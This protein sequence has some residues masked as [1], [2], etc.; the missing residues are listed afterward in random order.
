MEIF[1]DLEKKSFII[2]LV[3]EEESL[4]KIDYYQIKPRLIFTKCLKKKLK[5]EITFGDFLIQNDYIK[6][7][8]H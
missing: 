1:Y 5:T 8:N 7:Y 6:G 3:G 2:L 4:F